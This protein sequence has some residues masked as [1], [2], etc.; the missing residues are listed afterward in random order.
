MTRSR[1]VGAARAVIAMSL[2]VGLSAA[3]L[4]C[5]GS[6]SSSSS[7]VSRRQL[8]AIQT[9]PASIAGSKTALGKPSGHR[10][11]KSS[12]AGAA[13]ELALKKAF[14]GFSSC[15]RAN[16][17]NYPKANTSGGGPISDASHQGK[18]TQRSK[19]AYKKCTK[20]LVAA[21]K[22]L[23]PASSGPGHP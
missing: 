22:A 15:M 10:A 3:L 9:A 17:G 5:G 12:A 13:S 14:T 2:A 6:S 7:S 18:N 23:R 4:A 20:N 21:L 16:G 11:S 1:V 19:A 8:S